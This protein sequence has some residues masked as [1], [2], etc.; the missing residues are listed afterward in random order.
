MEDALK[1]N[2]EAELAIG[3]TAAN[4]FAAIQRLVVTRKAEL[5]CAALLLLMAVNLFAQISRKSITNDEL[6]HIPAGY[7]HL[8]AGKF[9]LNNEHPPLIKMWA[10]LPLLFIQP[11][12]EAHEAPEESKGTFAEE[13]WKYLDQFWS[14]NRAHFAS[15][16]F[17]CRAMMVPITL[18][19]GVL[20]FVYARQLFGARA[21]LFAV[22]LYSLEP[23]VLA[24]GRIVH[25]DLP[26]AFA[27]LLFF[28]AVRYYLLQRTTGRVALLGLASGFALVVKF[29]M[30][31]LLPVLAC[32]A[33]AGFIFARRLQ[34][35]RKRL[36]LHLGVI[37]CLILLVVNA[38]Y[39]FRR[40]PLEAADVKWVQIM[41]PD[42]AN[43]W[44]TFFQLGSKVVPTY[45]LFGQYNVKLHNRD[46]HPSSLL[47]QYKRT[48]WWYYFPVAFALKT[49]LPSL[50]LSLAGLAWAFWC[51]WKKD[52]RFLWLIAPFAIYAALSM[53]SSINIGVRHFLPAFPFLFIMAGVFLDRL[54]RISY[55]KHL[56]VALVSLMFA[57][58]SIEI[59]RSYPDYIPYMNQL[60]SSHP[61]WWYLSDSNVEWGD[62]AAAL[63]DYLHA[64]GETEVKGALLGAWGSLHLY[65]IHYYEIFPK[66]GRYIPD[67]RY[68]AIGASFLNGST[69]AVPPDESGKLI[70][71]EQR[72]N[73]LANFR[74]QTPEMIF[75]NSIYLYRVRD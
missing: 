63:A 1:Q 60:A 22:A 15:I 46:G 69:I 11:T 40:P 72:I 39:S 2:R 5:V 26:A 8:V 58:T 61:H 29:S 41:S 73:Y 14:N 66:P 10:A 44:M 47:G 62:D 18:G 37:V 71:E 54:L 43:H 70:S 31:V 56:A 23:T 6:V 19:L 13:T 48:G 24:H 45:W 34:Q 74:N 16:S 35:D 21:A 28:L 4:F 36:V 27:Y 50:I 51:L 7:Y 9:Q 52:W 49:T 68:V 67:T 42:A 64:R 33:V 55:G 75:G 59:L 25:T 17:W 38:V 12:E 32:L 57:W 53:S 3:A 20:I 30:I 65:D